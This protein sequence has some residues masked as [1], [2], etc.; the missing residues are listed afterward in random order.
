MLMNKNKPNSDSIRRIYTGVGSRLIDEETAA[1]ITHIAKQLSSYGFLL[2]SGG[3]DG[4]DTAFYNGADE[5]EIY[6]P[7]NG[8]SGIKMQYPLNKEAFEFAE[9][10]HPNWSSLSDAVKKLMARNCYQ[11]LGPNLDDPSH[12][13]LCWTPDG[14]NAGED[15]T[16]ATG[17]TGQ[18]IRVACA[19]GVPVCNLNH[20][21]SKFQLWQLLN[22]MG[23]DNLE[24]F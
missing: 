1:T 13:L 5:S 2:R 20:P 11:V 12:F 22:D 18:A 6:I 24:D 3:A 17:G 8:Y 16:N 23:I 9:M 21:E 7:W 19:F 14:V 15:T 10:F 4:S